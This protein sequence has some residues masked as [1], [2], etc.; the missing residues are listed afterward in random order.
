MA[1]LAAREQ[2]LPDVVLQRRRRREQRDAVHRARANAVDVVEP[3]LAERD[4]EVLQEVVGGIGGDAVPRR[5]LV[6]ALRGEEHVIGLRAVVEVEAEREVA[7]ARVVRREVDHPA[8]G[9]LVAGDLRPHDEVQCGGQIL[10]RRER[11]LSRARRADIVGIG[12]VPSEHQPR[13]RAELVRERIR[14]EPARRR[15]RGCQAEQ[16]PARVVEV[17]RRLDHLVA[18]QRDELAHLEHGAIADRNP[19][20]DVRFLHVEH[21]RIS[22]RVRIVVIAQDADRVVLL[23]V[24]SGGQHQAH[25][26]GERLV[27]IALDAELRHVE[28]VALIDVVVAQRVRPAIRRRAGHALAAAVQVERGPHLDKGEELELVPERFRLGSLLLLGKP[29][30]R[31]RGRRRRSLG[32]YR[33][34]TPQCDHAGRGEPGPCSRDHVSLSSALRTTCRRATG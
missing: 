4:A 20:R 25:P 11:D 14:D 29:V 34:Q 8:N 1:I 15:E 18:E 12:A 10:R 9:V 27:G 22:E 33:C 13:L 28:R 23:R 2:A 31:R 3:L 6:E 30:L 32:P 19:R 5:A 16:V 21:R 26:E 17:R 7:E 24:L